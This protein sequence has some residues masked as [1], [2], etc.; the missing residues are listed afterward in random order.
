MKTTKHNRPMS[1]TTP[2]GRA[3]AGPDPARSSLICGADPMIENHLNLHELE[4]WL[5]VRA[6]EGWLGLSLGHDRPW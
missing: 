3:K 1:N 6:W 5:Q 4:V 2:R